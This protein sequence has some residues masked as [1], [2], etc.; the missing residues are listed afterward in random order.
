MSNSP[1][2]SVTTKTGLMP[3]EPTQQ[4]LRF[5]RVEAARIWPLRTRV[6]RPHFAPGKLC[7]FAQDEAPET[8]HFGLFETEDDP[9]CVAAMTLI[10]RSQPGLAQ[11]PAVQLRGMCVDPAMQ[12]Q[13]LGTRLFESALAPLALHL[14]QAHIIWCNARLSAQG[15]YE[16]LGFEPHGEAFDVENIGPHILMR[17]PANPA[18]AADDPP[19][20]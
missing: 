1:N 13:G 17:R 6:L 18:L 9:R 20:A 11:L 14:P 10:L 8:L 19:S 3:L 12:H 2:F 16:K 4:K 5:E 15:F 7:I